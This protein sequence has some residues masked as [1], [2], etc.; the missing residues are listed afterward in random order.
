MN[1]ESVGNKRME[2]VEM[3]CLRSICGLKKIDRFL[4][5]GIRRRC[6]K[7]VSVSQR[8][9]QGVLRWFG[10]VEGMTDERMA[11]RVYECDVRGVRR[12]GSLRKCWMNGVKDVLTRKGLNIQE[13]KVSVQDRNEWHSIYRG[14]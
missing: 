6:G 12:K 2:A 14:V 11:K 9:D 4:N 13:A 10:H 8:I 5:V 1:A 7:N 3:N